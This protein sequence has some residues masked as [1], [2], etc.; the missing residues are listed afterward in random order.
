MDN[1]RERLSRKKGV[2]LLTVP[3]LFS[4]WCGS[5]LAQM[6]LNYAIANKAEQYLGATG[7][8]LGFV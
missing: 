2:R 1:E 5:L 3:L 6:S 4:V 7:V 8:H